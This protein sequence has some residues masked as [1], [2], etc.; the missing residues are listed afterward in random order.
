MPTPISERTWHPDRDAGI[1]PPERW[2]RAWAPVSAGD[3]V[4]AYIRT[5]WAASHPDGEPFPEELAGDCAEPD[6]DTAA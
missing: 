2:I 4:M 1:A 3:W 5:L 6:G